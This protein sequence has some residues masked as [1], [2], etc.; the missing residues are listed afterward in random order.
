MRFDLGLDIG[1][2]DL[3]LPES[4]GVRGHVLRRGQLDLQSRNELG[5]IFQAAEDDLGALQPLDVQLRVGPDR[6]PLL[7]A[8][9]QPDQM[10]IPTVIS[11]IPP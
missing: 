1:Q 8:R 9:V 7:D 5:G 2:F 10:T 4:V 3:D 11:H 6:V